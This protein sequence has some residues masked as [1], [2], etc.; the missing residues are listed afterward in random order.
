MT[1]TETVAITLPQLDCRE[2]PAFDAGN[3][4]AVCAAFASA[5]S[6]TLQQAWLEKPEADFSPA[7]VRVGWRE[8]S[9]HL[10][11]EL[12]DADIFSRATAHN[13]RMWELGDA[14]E[15]F[16]SPEHSASY[17]EFHVTP[18]NFRLQLRLPDT[19]TLR[20]AQAENCFDHLLL[21]D[22]VFFSRAWVR[23]ENKKW[24]VS[25]EIPAAAVGG[26]DQPLAGTRWRF[27]FSRYDYVRGRKEPMFS[28]SSPHAVADF[29]R[30]DE[31]GTLNFV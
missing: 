4:D 12:D 13:Q 21:P 3:L 14:L 30:R 6:C 1:M 11:A 31:W 22:G 15:I 7:T 23:S 27:S 9:L 20:Q 26:A 18:N 8:N 25:A 24:F 19:V 10:L 28:S 5:D 17:V 29:H 16:L 2:L